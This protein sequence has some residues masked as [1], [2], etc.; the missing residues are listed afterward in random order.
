MNCQTS[1]RD[2]DV[3]RTGKNRAVR[4]MYLITLGIDRLTAIANSSP[5]TLLRKVAPNVKRSVFQ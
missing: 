3:V 1:A 5:S 2:A 4:A